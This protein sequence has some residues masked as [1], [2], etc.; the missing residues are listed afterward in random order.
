MQINR[1]KI[2]ITDKMVQDMNKKYIKN[3]YK[4]ND[5]KRKISFFYEK[6]LDEMELDE[7]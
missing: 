3:R 4:K 5:K 2:D 1:D 7:E 6:D